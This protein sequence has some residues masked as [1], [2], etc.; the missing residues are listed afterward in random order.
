M[1]KLLLIA[2]LISSPSFAGYGDWVKTDEA[3]TYE[4]TDIVHG[5]IKA[6]IK[7][8][9]DGTL[10]FALS[11][12]SEK[13]YVSESYSEPFASIFVVGGYQDFNL[14]CIGK[15]KAVAY[16][17]DNSV[18]TEIVHSLVSSGN[19]CLTIKADDDSVKMC[20]SGNGVEKIKEEATK[21]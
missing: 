19:V 18:N 5:N 16:A 2:T 6:L 10:R 21:L 11:L 14:Q 7:T 12:S 9:K 4:T 13:C 3:R 20:F 8:Y 1:K 17:V 15:N